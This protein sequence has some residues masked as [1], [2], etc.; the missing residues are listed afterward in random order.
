MDK[1]PD[2]I[3]L[4]NEIMI[5]KD[6]K[7]Q[8]EKDKEAVKSYF[9]DY[10]NQNTVFFHDLREKLDYLVENDYYEKEF[11]DKYSFKEIKE[12]FKIAYAKKF[13][14]P[15]FMSA[16]KFYNNYALKTSDDK[17][18]LERYE[19]RVAV[20]AL[21]LADGNFEKAKKFVKDLID[22]KYQPA[23][24]T[25]LSAGRKRRGEL[26][27]CFLLMVDDSMNA[28]ANAI[29]NA[30]QLSK[31]GGGVSF[32]LTDLRALGDPIKGIENRCS[33]VVPVMKLL[34]D[35]FSYANQLGSRDGAG[36]VW[37]NIFHLD[38]IDF[39]STKKINADEKARIK[40]L[41]LGLIVPDK[42]F[43]LVE[44]DYEMYLF[45]P[46]GIQ[47][48]Y[49]KRMSEIDISKIYEELVDNPRIRKK[50]IN[51]RDLLTMIAQVQVESGYPYFF[52][53]DNA[54]R[55]HPLSNEGKVKFS[56][57]CTEVLQLSET[58]IINDYYED[59]E[60]KRDISCNLGSLNIVNVMESKDIAGAVSSGIR[61]L[62]TVANKTRIEAVP[63]V[64]KANDEMKSVGLGAMNLH[65][66]LAKNKI[67][68]ES[69]D[70]VEFV[71]AFFSAVNY[72]SILESMKIAQETG[73]IF[74]GFK[75]SKYDTGE[76]F[77]QYLQNDYHPKSEKVE[78]LFKGIELPTKED[79]RA[80]KQLVKENGL[81]HSYRLAIAPTGS[82]SYV[83]SSTASISPITEKIEHR[84]YKDSDTY[85]PMPFLNEQT[86]FF[87][88]E[89]Y[90]MDMFKMIDVYAA[91]QEHIDQG[92]SCTLYVKDTI[93]TRELSMYYIYAWKKNLKTL[94]YT[95]T[96]MTNNI[97]E[98]VSCSV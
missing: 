9:V 23:T 61:M 8:F 14:F 19:D 52:F 49:G 7:F 46:Y 3:R 6:G 18:I 69:K 31:R 35:S 67:S 1:I 96:K 12:I 87:F 85:Y 71:H 48:E 13:R 2:Y 4:N 15:S 24:P 78:N 10:I 55:Q 27:S 50:K 29:N 37:L 45:S 32:N 17:K 93:T 80:L 54:N 77:E 66:F 75:G 60:I 92:I 90:D 21:F 84:T 53:E 51:A 42:F 11:L 83:Q 70:A 47:K 68:Y 28:I 57:L 36:A 89:A 65:G 41:S 72:Y 91:A 82:I 25:F 30:L 59:D 88:K 74:K 62:N 73:F 95:R 16:F 76:Y 38:V 98:C 26:V 34:E 5:Q 56:N 97:N 43:E 33:G 44:K 39:L 81:A 86:F 58:S 94:Y 79:W 22:G 63:S 40:T 64:A 20:N